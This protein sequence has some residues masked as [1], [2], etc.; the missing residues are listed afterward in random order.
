MHKAYGRQVE[1]MPEAD[2]S[3]IMSV[4]RLRAYILQLTRHF[5]DSAED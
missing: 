2:R 4:L 3:S 5:E 1:Q